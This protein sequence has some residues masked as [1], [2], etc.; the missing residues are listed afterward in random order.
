VFDGA[1]K[2]PICEDSQTLDLMCARIIA[3]GNIDVDGRT[4]ALYVTWADNRNGTAQNTNS[5]V[6]VTRSGDGGRTW[7][8]AHNLTRG[9]RDYQWFPWL[10][11]SPKGTVAV[12]YFDRR[13]SGPKLIDTSLSVST[14]EARTFARRRVSDVS[15]NPDLAFRLGIFIGDYNALDTTATTAF[16]VWTDARFGEPNVPGNNPPRQQSDVWV[17]VEPLP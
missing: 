17:D 2:Y 13:Y 4:G 1:D 12:T 9:S 6:F 5:D 14:N 8:R 15:W 16:P 7:S 10:S 11:V 3:P